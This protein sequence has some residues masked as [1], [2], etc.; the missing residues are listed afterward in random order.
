MISAG[1]NPDLGARLAH[2]LPIQGDPTFLK[3]LSEA[4]PYE[5]LFIY[6]NPFDPD[7]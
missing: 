3:E 4:D 6:L 1:S 7:G 5:C 2:V